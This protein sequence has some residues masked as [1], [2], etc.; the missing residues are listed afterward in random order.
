MRTTAL[1]ET[2]YANLTARKG[3]TAFLTIGVAAGVTLLFFL[4][5]LSLGIRQFLFDRF[6]QNFPATE[7]EVRSAPLLAQN[8]PGEKGVITPGVIAQI[9]KMKG[10]QK[11]LPMTALSFP[12]KVSGQLK[13]TSTCLETDCAV[14][15][16]PVELLAG[17][18]PPES[19]AEF[20]HRPPDQPVPVVISDNL[21]EMYNS[22]FSMSQGLPRIEKGHLLGQ[23]FLLFLGVSSFS[24]FPQQTVPPPVQCRVVGVSR[25]VPLMGVSVPKEYVEEWQA[26]FGAANQRK[27]FYFALRVRT[28]SV[29]DTE[30]VAKEIE[31]TGLSVQSGKEVLENVAAMTNVTAAFLGLIGFAVLL[32]AGIGIANAMAMSVVEQSVRIGILRASGARKKDVLDIFVCE[33]MLVGAVGSAAG[34][35]LGRGM[36]G[37]VNYLVL[38][39]TP[40]FPFKPETLF[41][42]PWWAAL[43]V[44]LFG[45]AIASLAGLP[46]AIRA[47]NLDPA[48]AL[49]SG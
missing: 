33:A 40:P 30:R 37:I 29:L 3:R 42:F 24:P 36:C 8:P 38:S 22:S 45:T 4:M 34:I 48:T 27:P 41:A 18:V 35:V 25:N 19:L 49:R 21:V 44:F 13:L 15:G 11:V 31:K 16:I 23:T 43:L 5:S 7:I 46:P 26:T 17:D 6:V 39:L 20:T 28:A 32:V 12:T 14:Y 9:E 10:V 2:S 1:L 47:A